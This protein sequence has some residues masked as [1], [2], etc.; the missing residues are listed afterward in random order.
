MTNRTAKTFAL[1]SIKLIQS[2]SMRAWALGAHNLPIIIT[3]ASIHKG[4]KADFA[5]NLTLTAMG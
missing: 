3:M 2:D 1:A 4:T 5:A